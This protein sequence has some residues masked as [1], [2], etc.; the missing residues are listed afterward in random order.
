[1]RSGMIAVWD[2]DRDYR[3]KLSAYL[4]QHGDRGAAVVAFGA[5]EKLR[6][7]VERGQVSVTVAARSL[8]EEAWLRGNPTVFLTEMETLETNEKN[9]SRFSQGGEWQYFYKYQPARH[10]LRCISTLQ[11]RAYVDQSAETEMPVTE[12]V[13]GKFARIRGIY[14]PLGGCLKTSFGLVLGCLLAEEKRC[15]FLSLEAH[16]GFRTLFGRQYPM[17]LSDLFACLRQKQSMGSMLSEALQP[18]G[19]LQYIPPVIWPVDIREAEFDE[20]REV[21]RWLAQC[22][23]FDEIVVDVGQDLACPERVLMLCDEI[24]QLEKEDV[25]SRAKLAE[26]EAY[27]RI[28]GYDEISERMQRIPLSRLTVGTET[29]ELDQW[30]RWEQMIPAVRR[31]L[32]EVGHEK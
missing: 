2:P 6:Q 19:S 3:E 31:I 14:S 20:L 11:Q 23:R 13:S 29:A 9:D 25:F 32:K 8:E 17:D 5:M 28:S 26:Y 18:F 22:G 10:L 16:A 15:L 12:Y 1:M 24:Y 4:R 21:L 27:L 7:A 30:Q